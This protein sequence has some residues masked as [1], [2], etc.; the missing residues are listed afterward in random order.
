MLQTYL[1][2]IR[3]GSVFAPEDKKLILERLFHPAT[4]GLVKDDAAPPSP[5]EILSRR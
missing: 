2:I 4:D 5:L 1:S 3:E